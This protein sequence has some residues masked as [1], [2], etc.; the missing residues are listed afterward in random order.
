MT[1]SNLRWLERLS[2]EVRTRLRS[3]GERCTFAQGSVLITRDDVEA[4]LFLIE[5]GGVRVRVAGAHDVEVG[6]GEIVGE[7]AF[8]DS[9]PRR[10]DVIAVAE[11]EVRRIERATLLAAFFDAPLLL[12]ELLQAIA[13]VGESRRASQAPDGETAEAFVQRLASEALR[14]R[15]VRHPYLAALA[16]GT[17]PDTRWA[18]S[19][20][21]R[22]YYAYSSHFPRYLTTVISR[23]ERP[24]HRRALLENLTEES[25]VYEDE[26]LAELAK[27]GVERE[28]IEGIPHPVLFRRFADSIGVRHVEGSERDHV[29]AWRDLFLQVLGNSAAEG[30]GALGLGTENIVRTIY[31]PFV[32][33]VARLGELSPRDTVFFP[34]HTAVDDHHQAT[35]QALS[36]DHAQ[37][38]EGRSE[39]RRGMLKA[40]QLRSAF[41]DWMLARALEPAAADTVV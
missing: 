12:S 35:L 28:W 27:L 32:K 40:L 41:W 9:A 19:D 38:A 33:A 30:L 17:L 26:E 16:D 36:V 34:L 4:H 13:S 8:L 3:C 31:G 29:V 23:L 25:G 20:F 21:A 18:L 1:T 37:T 15:A 11:S 5:T 7:M 10:F 14:H 6:P 22:Q 2:P 39:L 24:E